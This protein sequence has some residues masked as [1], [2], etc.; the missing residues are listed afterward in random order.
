MSATKHRNKYVTNGEVMTDN[1][2]IRHRLH[3]LFGQIEK[4]FDG[5]IT[6]NVAL[7]ERVETL[8]ELILSSGT[9]QTDVQN[10]AL[11]QKLSVNSVKRDSMVTASQLSAKIKSTYKL[12]ATGRNLF[13]GQ[14][15]TAHQVGKYE[16]HK[17]G[18]W[19]ITSA[20]KQQKHFIATAS[21]DGTA[22]VSD[23]TKMDANLTPLL[24]YVG[25]TGC[26]VNCVKFHPN[27]D[28]IMT[29]A[30][31]GTSHIWRPNLELHLQRNLEPDEAMQD[32]TNDHQLVN[33]KSEDSIQIKTPLCELTGH[34]SVV[35]SCDWISGVDQC[36]TASWDRT[37][38]I[39]DIQTGELVVQLAGH[40]Q[41]L[42]DVCAHG[43][44]RLIVTSSHDTTFRLWDFRDAI[45]SVSVF[46]GH[47]ESVMSASFLGTDK[48]ISGSDD[49]TLKVWDLRNMRSALTSIYVESPLNKFSVSEEDNLIAIPLDNR[50]VRVY[51]LSGN[52]VCRLSRS[53]HD[54][55]VTCCS[56]AAL[57]QPNSIHLFTCSFDRRVCLWD[58][59]TEVKS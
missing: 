35:I 18:L 40:D 41:E 56:F 32:G 39:Y 46:Q 55:M 44:T 31:D 38:N 20:V 51:D 29:A 22:V 4:E 1:P 52:R 33:Q 24:T 59:I 13:K 53:Q 27:Y 36:V 42:T 43:S 48:V 23:V 11:Q 17:D 10:R 26:S 8:E 12:K 9:P 25:H 2:D 50:H 54:R 7:K 37:A 58:I 49:R 15:V 5:L 16:W 45:H 28:L 19:Y 3:H 21:A 57:N 14:N 34:Q 47:T 6:E 30:G